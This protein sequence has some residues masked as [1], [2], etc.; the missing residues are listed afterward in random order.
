MYNIGICRFENTTGRQKGIFQVLIKPFFHR[1][2]YSSKNLGHP[3]HSWSI[4]ATLFV[5]MQ[6]RYLIYRG[7]KANSSNSQ[8]VSVSLSL[9]LC[10]Y[11]CFSSI[12]IY[13]FQRSLRSFV[14]FDRMQKRLD[15]RET[16]E[17]SGINYLD[18]RTF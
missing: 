4:T 18:K 13:F 14:S 16:D 3:R 8:D 17:D 6:H 7:N 10:W 15:K 9:S 5:S 1:Q 12:I 11:Q 2:S